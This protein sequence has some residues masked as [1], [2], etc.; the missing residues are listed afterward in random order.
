MLDGP[1]RVFAV[2]R[3]VD[4]VA[5]RVYTQVVSYATPLSQRSTHT[6]PPFG[7]SRFTRHRQHRDAIGLQGTWLT[8]WIVAQHGQR[9]TTSQSWTSPPHHC[10]NGVSELSMLNCRQGGGGQDTC[11]EG[12]RGDGG[13]GSVHGNQQEIKRMEQPLSPLPEGGLG[14]V[15]FVLIGAG[16]GRGSASLHRTVGARGRGG[17][18]DPPTTAHTAFPRTPQQP[19]P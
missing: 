14:M 3:K 8:C 2:S 9:T 10:P 11:M 12:A 1:P 13:S 15:D 18:Q 6:R 5:I 17:G 7:F 19:T 4:S 16:G